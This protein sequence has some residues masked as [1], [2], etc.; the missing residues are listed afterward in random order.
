LLVTAGTLADEGRAA[1]N[2][3]AAAPAS[4]GVWNVDG[5]SHASGLATAPTEW[6]TR[7]IGFLDESIGN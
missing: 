3:K 5:A 1:A 4:V 7:V 2:F 6:E